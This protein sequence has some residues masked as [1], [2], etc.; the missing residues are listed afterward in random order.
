M[1]YMLTVIFL[2]GFITIPAFAQDVKNPSIII[3]TIEI[4][5]YLDAA[6]GTLVA[7]LYLNKKRS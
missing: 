6:I 7:V 1:K 3:D 5:F 4:P 2:L